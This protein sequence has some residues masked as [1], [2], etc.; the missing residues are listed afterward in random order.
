MRTLVPFHLTL[1]FA[2]GAVVAHGKPARIRFAARI[3]EEE[4]A[5]AMVRLL[6]LMLG[7]S[8]FLGCATASQP[9]AKRAALHGDVPTDE[10]RPMVA[11]HLDGVRAC[12]QQALQRTIGLSGRVDFRIFVSAAG[13]VEKVSRSGRALDEELEACVIRAALGWSFPARRERAVST[14]PFVFKSD[15]GAA[16]V[17]LGH[18][19]TGSLD[20]EE[21]RAV[22]RKHLGEVKSCY[23]KGLAKDPTL[24]GRVMLQFLIASTGAVEESKIID[25]RVGDTGDCIA[26]AALGWRFPKPSGGGVVIVSYPFILEPQP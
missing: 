10:I 21:I 7:M 8:G 14:Y 11:A 15:S 12:Y 18:A 13:A 1:G 20:K 4:L 25:G 17:D 22:I 6:V 16:L 2:A 9:V 26:A 5:G 24:N 19:L 3:V 23:V